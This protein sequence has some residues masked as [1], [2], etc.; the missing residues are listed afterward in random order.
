MQK[1][2]V[3]LAILLS[4][5]CR[6]SAA[7]PPFWP[8]G[9]IGTPPFGDLTDGDADKLLALASS[10]GLELRPTIEKVY[11]G[12]K[13][14]LATLLRFSTQL[15][16]LDISTRAYGNMVYS[17]FLNLGE[18][19]SPQLF[20]PV[21]LDQPPQVRQ[22]VRDFLWYPMFCVPEEHR[23]EVER[24]VHGDFPLLFPPDF[25]FGKDDS[26]FNKAPNTALPPPVSSVTPLAVASGAPIRP[27]RYRER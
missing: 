19:K 25:V 8:C 10:N 4:G 16:S 12:D 6:A 18:A 13:E 3:A 5:W 21:L 17:I 26:L 23:A 20:I 15:K 27:A 2:V 7:G 22:R 9:S 11:A 1:V 24:E 14:A